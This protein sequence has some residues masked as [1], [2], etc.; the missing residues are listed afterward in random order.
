MYLVAYVSHMP[1]PS[2]KYV[3]LPQDMLNPLALPLLVA[4]G[5]WWN[6]GERNKVKHTLYNVLF[7]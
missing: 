3:T 1:P 5:Q 6:D 2:K 4:F 7:I